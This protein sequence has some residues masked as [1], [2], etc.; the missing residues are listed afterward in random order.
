M[1][2]LLLIPCT[3]FAQTKLV[4]YDSSSIHPRLPSPELLRELKED[5]DYN[6][7]SDPPPTDNLIAKWW[8][9]LLQQLGTFFNSDSYA[10]FWQYVVMI[11]MAILVLFLLYKAK[12]LDYV[13]PPAKDDSGL[14]YTI[15]KENIHEINFDEA[16]AQAYKDGDFRLAIR[17]QYLKTLKVLTDRSLITWT[18]HRTNHNYAED[19]GRSPLRNDF[20]KITRY[21]E[22]AWYG[23]FPIE[24]PE[25]LEMKEW[26]NSF[27]QKI[28]QS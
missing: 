28:K 25:F 9:W 13:F 4:K 1:I 8:N 7:E 12:V 10:E 5:P 2:A 24:E 3:H 14:D 27:Y 23:A 26:S 6:Y 19:L 16:I 20:E 22:F 21:F 18:P 17:L 11:A 15:G